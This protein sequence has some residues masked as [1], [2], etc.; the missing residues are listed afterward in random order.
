MA[1][2]RTRTKSRG[3]CLC[4]LGIALALLVQ[5]STDFARGVPGLKDSI[6]A[7]RHPLHAG[8]ARRAGAAQEDNSGQDWRDLE[9][10]ADQRMRAEFVEEDLLLARQQLQ[11]AL[12]EQETAQA[13]VATAQEQ[14]ATAQEQEAIAVRRLARAEESGD[15]KKVQAAERKV[16]VAERK[17]ERAKKEVQEAERKVEK[18]KKEVEKAER[19]VER[20]KK[21]VK[22]AKA[23]GRTKESEV[24]IAEALAEMLFNTTDTQWP[25]VSAKYSAASSSIIDLSRG[26]FRG[27]LPVGKEDKA[28]L[29]DRQEEV[30]FIVQQLKMRADDLKGRMGTD[31]RASPAMVVAQA[32]GS[33]KSHFLA[34]LGE[35]LPSLYD[36]EG[37]NQTPIVS[38]FTYN[39][40]MST[41]LKHE[42]GKTDVLADLAL[43]IIYGAAR[44]MTENGCQ[45]CSWD[46]FLHE[47]R[48]ARRNEILATL[49]S[50]PT[51][52]VKLLRNWYGA[53]P[54]VI[55][56]DEVGKSE[57]EAAVRH[58]LCNS[59]D[60]WGGQAF[61]VMSALSEYDELKAMFN[62]SQRD[63]H[64]LALRT[65]DCDTFRLFSAML[66]KLNDKQN[67]SVKRNILEYRIALAWG[68]TGGYA[69][70]VEI[71]AEY[72][73][74]A[75]LGAGLVLKMA[76]DHLAKVNHPLPPS[77]TL[78]VLEEVL[79]V[80]EDDSRMF[81]LDKLLAYSAR[82]AK[83]IYTGSVLLE[84]LQ[85]GAGYYPT[86]ASWHAA[87]LFCSPVRREKEL[88][89][90]LPRCRKL[91]EMA[92]QA[93]KSKV[94]AVN[95]DEELEII[96]QASAY[97]TEVAAAFGVMIAIVKK[98]EK[99]PP[100]LL[101]G[102]C[103]SICD[104]GFDDSLAQKSD[105][106]TRGE[107]DAPQKLK[108]LDF[109]IYCKDKQ[110]LVAVQVKSD[111]PSN[112]KTAPVDVSVA[113]MRREVDCEP[114]ND[115]DDEASDVE[116]PDMPGFE[117]LRDFQK[118]SLPTKK[119]CL[120]P[121]R[122]CR[123]LALAL[124][125]HL[126]CL[127]CPVAFLASIC[128]KAFR[129]SHNLQWPDELRLLEL[130]A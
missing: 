65:L 7:K 43:R 101:Q 34:K 35:Q 88:L 123:R 5:P 9:E 77:F 108:A 36:L 10:A 67:A 69:R 15:A 90:I 100:A 68:T 130:G 44:H 8:V 104:I 26:A 27:V 2:M 24:D 48:S 87:Q 31:K 33:G 111:T 116:R 91:M 52:A 93:Y 37:N 16:Q 106:A 29:L 113:W 75:E 105:L 122:I 45:C 58:C 76:L 94:A 4:L 57:D 30:A 72:I 42:S 126:T 59:M 79:A 114:E 115:A 55:L 103:Q 73:G 80:W 97:L 25:L 32:P 13:Q 117:W 20:A 86:V 96:K 89:G 110:A 19:K 71:L 41:A 38:A 50:D 51:F 102:A 54:L 3:M 46:G 81:S 84:S 60:T 78:E 12:E 119:L 63:Y 1:M 6:L 98:Y 92:G 62:G 74:R 85:L 127:T 11:F 18:A 23:S 129:V 56:A 95:Q 61:V 82:F 120:L 49:R 40:G 128:G 39:S 28:Q 64:I 70:A 125:R 14:V 47:L 109:V 118:A 83:A 53:R 99:L 112:R 107:E 121:L 66:Q 21:E 17:V 22:E 124:T